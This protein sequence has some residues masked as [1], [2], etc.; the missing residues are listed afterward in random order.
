MEIVEVLMAA[1]KAAAG[2]YGKRWNWAAE[3][4]TI[5]K[6]IT[7]RRADVNKPRPVAKP[8]PAPL[9][10]EG[11]KVVNMASAAAALKTKPSPKTSLDGWLIPN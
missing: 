3:E 4:R 9:P 1:T 5:R 2:D 7:K 6:D 11:S 8:K 10:T